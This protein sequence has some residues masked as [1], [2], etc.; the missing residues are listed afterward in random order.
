M[1]L[2]MFEMKHTKNY[3]VFFILRLA[4][5]IRIFYVGF[6]FRLDS[7]DRS[8]LIFL[9]PLNDLWIHATNDKFALSSLDMSY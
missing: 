2:E 8:Y 7:A 3:S 4:S 1:Y 9:F 6:Y 5:G